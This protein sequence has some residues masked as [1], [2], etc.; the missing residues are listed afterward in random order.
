MITFSTRVTLVT[1]WE[2]QSRGMA[3]IARA[4]SKQVIHQLEREHAFELSDANDEPESTIGVVLTGTRVKFVIVGG[5]GPLALAYLK[6]LSRG[7]CRRGLTCALRCSL[8]EQPL[9][10]RPAVGHAL[11]KNDVV[12]AVDHEQASS[13]PWQHAH[14]ADADASRGPSVHSASARRRSRSDVFLI[15][16]ARERIL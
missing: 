14:H 9:G 7:R 10:Y 5:P 16:S 11:Q 15:Q 6:V 2:N 1:V 13:L 4:V 8:R 3:D 12:L